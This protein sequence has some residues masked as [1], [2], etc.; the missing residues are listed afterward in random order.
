MTRLGGLRLAGRFAA[1]FVVAAVLAACA[2]NPTGPEGAG[3]LSGLPPAGGGG[4][5]TAEAI[6]QFQV[7]VGD[8]VFFDTDSSE[9]SATARAT[10]DRQ[11][12]WLQLY[13][14]AI[15]VIE[16]H[17][18]ERGTREYNLALGARRATAVRN[19][20][21]SRG[22]NGSRITTISYGKERPVAVCDDISCWSQN[23][24]A[25]TAVQGGI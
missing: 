3:G 17:A 1:L 13:P 2:Q 15:V 22:I 21:I 7:S 16:G 4:P 8:R 19:Y 5:V 14:T 11:A 18:D 25:V 24:R 20:L 6:Q 12:Q 10:L 23:R 9:L